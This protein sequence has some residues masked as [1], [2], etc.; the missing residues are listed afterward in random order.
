MLFFGKKKKKEDASDSQS[1]LD[2]VVIA[3]G[4]IGAKYA[5]T[6]HNAGWIVLDSLLSDSLVWSHNK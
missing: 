6:R 4:N 3:L 5:T 2:L 1:E